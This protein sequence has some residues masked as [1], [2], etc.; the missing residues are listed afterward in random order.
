MFNGSLRTNAPLG[1]KGGGAAGRGARYAA[2]KAP[3]S[4][5]PALRRV[6]PV[7]GNSEDVLAIPPPGRRLPYQ[8]LKPGNDIKGN[9]LCCLIP[10]SILFDKNK[11]IF[12]DISG[13]RLPAKYPPIRIDR[14]TRGKRSELI[15]HL[16]TT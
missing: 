6:S 4:S 16:H 7:R 13:T 10:I 2:C 11:P 14:R 3:P 5:F 9:I 15:T 1:V 8:G 12:A